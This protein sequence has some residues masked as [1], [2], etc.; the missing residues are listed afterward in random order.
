VLPVALGR[1]ASYWMVS[2][3]LGVQFWTFFAASLCFDFGM[4]MFF[5]LYNLFLIDHGYKEDFLG[6]MTSAMNLG[7][8]AMTIPAGILVHRLGLRRTMVFCLLLAPGIFVMRAFFVSRSALLWFALLA[9][10]AITI[11]AVAISPAIARLTDER[12]RAYGFSVVFASG[13]GVGVLANLVASRMP[14]WFAQLTPAVSPAQAKRLTLLVAC[15]IL[16]LAPSRSPAC[17]ST[18]CRPVRKAFIREIGFC[19]AFC[20]HWRFGVWSP[21][22]S[23]RFR[24]SISRS[25]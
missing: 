1:G 24:T 22:L 19:G 17:A 14:G 5:F 3:R 15:A 8:L 6:I 21:V 25:T 7:S 4:T 2:K 10:A 18:R 9:G 11:W 12:N 13:I 23:A 16:L 20:R